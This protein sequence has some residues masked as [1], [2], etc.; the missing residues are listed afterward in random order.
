MIYHRRNVVVDVDN[1]MGSVCKGWL[2]YAKPTSDRSEI[3]FLW[4]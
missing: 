3:R 1:I 4:Q 2:E